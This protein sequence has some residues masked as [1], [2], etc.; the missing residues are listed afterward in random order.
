MKVLIACEAY[1]CDLLP[2]SGDYPE[3]HYQC[4]IF[5]I[6][7]SLNKLNY[8]NYDTRNSRKTNST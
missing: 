1:S 6:I 4:D 5:E 7:D 2:C 3:W 8:F